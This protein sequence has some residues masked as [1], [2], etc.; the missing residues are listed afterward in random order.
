MANWIVEKDKN[1][2]WHV[3]EDEK[4]KFQTK[5]EAVKAGQEKAKK[6]KTTL[7]IHK[8][9][10]AG[11]DSFDYSNAKSDKE[12]KQANKE[13]LAKA[14]ENLATKNAKLKEAKAKVKDAKDKKEAKAK[15]KKAKEDVKTAKAKLKEAKAK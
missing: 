13:A 12:K 10:A 15:V 7:R 4:G 1:N 14:K 3:R 6:D 5:D 11:Y 9:D 2:F 8:V